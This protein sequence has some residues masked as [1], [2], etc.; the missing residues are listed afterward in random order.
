MT[1]VRFVLRG[2]PFASS[3]WLTALLVGAIFLS[4]LGCALDAGPPGGDEL[5]FRFPGQAAQVLL[6][7][8]EF[9]AVDQELR[10]RLDERFDPRDRDSVRAP[11]RG[12]WPRCLRAEKEGPL[13]SAR[14]LRDRRARDRR[15]GR[16]RGR[17]ARRGVS[18]PGRDVV[19]VCGRRWLRGVAAPRCRRGERRRAGGGVGG[20]RRDAA[21][22]GRRGRGRRRRGRAAA[23]GDG[24]GGVRERRSAGRRAARG[25]RREDRALGR[26]GRRGGAGRPGVGAGR[27][28]ERSAPSYTATPLGNGQVLVVGGRT[29]SSVWGAPSC[30]I[31]YPIPGG[32]PERWPRPATVIRRRCSA[33]ARCWSWAGTRSGSVAHTSAELYDPA[34]NT[35]TRPARWPRAVARHTATLLGERQGAGRRGA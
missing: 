12:C 21:T 33:T 29:A 4:G 32:R 20:R 16:G 18:A 24:A 35:W 7:N 30:T 34:S 23:A 13:P 8:E 9:V 27:I 28:H 26:R 1:R 19:L 10:A 6:G 17:R 11:R 2:L 22:A 15:R 5:R 3:I 14:R 25:A 31:R